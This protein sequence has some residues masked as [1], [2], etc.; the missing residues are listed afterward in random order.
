MFNGTQGDSERHTLGMRWF[1]KCENN[2]DGEME[3]AYQIG[4]VGNEGVHAWTVASQVGYRPDG[5]S[6]RYWLGLDAASGD[7]QAG[8]GVETFD[9][10][11]PLGHAYY[12]YIDAI[13]RQNATDTSVGAT[14]NPVPRLALALS[15]HSFW[16]TSKDDAIYN[17]G[18]GVVRAPGSFN[19][20]WIGWEVDVT[21]TWRHDEQLSTQLGVSR[22][23]AGDALEESGP[24]EDVSFAYIEL[25]YSL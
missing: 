3:V 24:S 4:E 18:G 19:S 6:V 12:G 25:N 20:S 13:G 8:G 15:G 5:G 9:P 1:G 2:V 10:L 21:A 17:A 22:F 16:L 11:Y 14:C 23:Y 7:D